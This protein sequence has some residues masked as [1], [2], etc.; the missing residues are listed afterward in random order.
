MY[1]IGLGDSKIFTQLFCKY[2]WWTP[3]L[4]NVEV[5]VP[6]CWFVPQAEKQCKLGDQNTCGQGC[7][8]L[9][10]IHQEFNMCPWTITSHG[11]KREYID[12]QVPVKDKW[13][14]HFL[15]KLLEQ[16]REMVICEEDIS[17]ITS[18]V[19]S[20]CSSAEVLIPPAQ[21]ELHPHTIATDLVQE[22][23]VISH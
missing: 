22:N 11:F 12:Y 14:L 13:R 7:K 18:L 8:N 3:S 10:I 20:L 9:R 5:A 19:D 2:F 15:K 23:T 17:T 1:K 4:H 16:R 6:V 21:G